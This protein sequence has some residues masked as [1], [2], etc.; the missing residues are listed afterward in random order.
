VNFLKVT[1]GWAIATAIGLALMEDASRIPSRIFQSGIYLTI[2][3]LLA[4]SGTVRRLLADLPALWRAGIFCS[5]GVMVTCQLAEHSFA[6][7]PAVAWDMYAQRVPEDP[8][9]FEFTGVTSDDR[10]VQL[11]FAY[12]FAVLN[13]QVMFGLANLASR[14]DREQDPAARDRLS[15][16]Y[17][18]TVIAL[19]RTYDK[20][21]SE[22]ELKTIRTWRCT[23]PSQPFVEPDTIQR[24]LEHELQIY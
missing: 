5:L 17:I 22:F 8:H 11:N 18:E 4:Q 24:R 3:L 6:T 2:A 23:I 7:F 16:E 19:A 1:F 20:A 12:E 14:I 15:R 13:R 10:E 21:H 9:Y